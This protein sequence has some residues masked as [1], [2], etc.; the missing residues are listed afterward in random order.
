M[1]AKTVTRRAH[2]HYIL[3]I[4]ESLINEVYGE[5]NELN[6]NKS[7]NPIMAADM[8]IQL[9]IQVFPEIGISKSFFLR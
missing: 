9:L 7:Q 6:K 2:S 8:P 3:K 5:R 4:Q 1:L